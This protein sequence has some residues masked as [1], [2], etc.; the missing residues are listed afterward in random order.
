MIK[1]DLNG[2]FKFIENSP[3]CF[4]VAEN[5]KNELINSGFTELQENKSWTI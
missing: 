2:L 5:I 4:Q 3:T 1:N